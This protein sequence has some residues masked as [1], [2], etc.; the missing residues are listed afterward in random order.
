[1]NDKSIDDIIKRA[2]KALYKAKFSGRNQVCILEKVI[3]DT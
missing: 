2:D 3:D 1:M